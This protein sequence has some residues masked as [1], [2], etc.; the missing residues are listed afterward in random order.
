M[1]LGDTRLFT[2]VITPPF[3]K[4][5]FC[6]KVVVYHNSNQLE[7]PTTEIVALL[8]T[9]APFLKKTTLRQLSQVVF[10]ML[11][12]SGRI[13]MLGLSLTNVTTSLL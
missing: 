9:I 10:G 1:F 11:V 4:K 7:K 3:L 5:G 2:S 13:T 8:Q 12:A 6:S